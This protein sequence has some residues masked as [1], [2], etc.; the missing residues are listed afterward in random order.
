MKNKIFKKMQEYG[1]NLGDNT[2]E[3]FDMV[4]ETHKNFLDGI[5]DYFIETEV[6]N[7]C[8]ED[9]REINLNDFSEEDMQYMSEF[10]TDFLRAL[11]DIDKPK[12]KEE[13]IRE[14]IMSRNIQYDLVGED[15]LA[16][17]DD[18]YEEE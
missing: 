6:Y 2:F 7:D 4:F 5:Y 14:Y 10:M 18:K 8:N 11:N 17:L 16:I 9:K 15:L 12:T 3:D 1:W 13:K